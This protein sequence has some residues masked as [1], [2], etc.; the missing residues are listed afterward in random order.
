MDT[1]AAP[2]H[3]LL[4]VRKSVQVRSVMLWPGLTGMPCAELNARSG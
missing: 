4:D 3:F 1:M 2:L